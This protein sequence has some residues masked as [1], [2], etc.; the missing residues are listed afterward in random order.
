MS[1]CSAVLTAMLSSCSADLPVQRES[2]Q[3]DGTVL[4]ARYSIVCVIHGDGDYVY[5]DNDGT[6]YAADEKILVAAQRV[7]QQNPRAEVFIFHQRP[8]SH[9][10]FLFPLRDGDFYY[11]RN[12][13]LVTELSYWRDQEQ[14]RFNAEVELYRRFRADNPGEMMNVFLY[15]GH[16]IP[17]AGGVGY[18]A[19]YPERPFTVHDLAGRLQEFT[20]DSTRFD[21]VVL[22]TCF[23][24]TPYT[25]GTLGPFARYIIASPG[26]LHLSYFDLHS[27]ER[28]DLS[29]LGGDVLAL[30][31]QFA[32]H[33]FD[34]LTG[35]VQTAVSVAVYDVDRTRDFV[36]SVRGMYDH[37]LTT[38]SGETQASIPR[39]EHCDCADIP[40]YMLPAIN[41]GVDVFYRPARFG[42]LKH[43]QNHSGWECWRERAPQGA[44]SQIT[45]AVVK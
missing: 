25:I 7:A 27:L 40:A 6:E 44:A 16:E 34:R 11:Y 42:R 24:G 1:I 13:R 39:M 2:Q 9:V 4:T 41:E 30:A 8:R 10:L 37:A 36:R 20:R 18:D 17:E 32:Q 31:K 29:V 3:A 19:S 23:G 45:G 5:H 12:G 43:K 28:L 26:N 33:A 35:D 21:L 15:Y 14:S 22:S 38:V